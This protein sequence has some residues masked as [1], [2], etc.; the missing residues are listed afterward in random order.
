MAQ[1]VSRLLVV[2]GQFP[3]GDD[4]V[5]WRHD[6]FASRPR[7]ADLSF[8]YLS[9]FQTGGGFHLRADGGARTSQ[10]CQAAV[11]W[12]E[13]HWPGRGQASGCLQTEKYPPSA[14]LLGEGEWLLHVFARP[15]PPSSTGTRVVGQP[16]VWV[17][18]LREGLRAGAA[19]IVASRWCPKNQ[20]IHFIVLFGCTASGRARRS[21]GPLGRPI[22]RG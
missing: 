17:T 19:S 10:S 22:G 2:L 1:Y 7:E 5:H 14:L 15:W 11:L 12:N 4:G 20:I 3:D 8:F 9:A 6:R 16:P 13:H 18:R 21:W